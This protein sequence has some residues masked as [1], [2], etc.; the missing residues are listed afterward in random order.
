M[1][2]QYESPLVADAIA[3][4]QAKGAVI[5]GSSGNNGLDHATSPASNKNPLSPPSAPV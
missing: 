2:A 1:G 5:V 3:A 4:A